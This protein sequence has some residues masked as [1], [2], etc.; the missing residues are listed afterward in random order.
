MTTPETAWPVLSLLERRVLGVLVEKAKTTPDV[1]P[2]SLNSLVN[3]CNQKSNRDPVM[4][5]QEDQI[6]ETLEVLCR[7]G[8]TMRVIGGRVDRWRQ[9]LYEAWTV[10]KL[11]L[12]ILAELLLRGPQTEA[13]L[14]R[15]SDRM[16]QF[17]DMETFKTVLKPLLDRK[18]VIYLGPENRRGTLLTH[19]FHD[20]RELEKLADHG[21]SSARNE[22][23]S[24]TEKVS[25]PPRHE[26]EASLVELKA[27][28]VSLKEQM[29]VL[30][31][32]LAALKQ[33]LGG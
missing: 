13:E 6:E 16:E 24:A 30:K 25:L 14:R 2:M 26:M 12:A 21:S 11:E 5:L 10:T 1:Y 19:G 17:P 28:I 18:L 32:Q 33:S 20:P 4:N 8:L 15:N 23:F 3:G 22:D 29:E 27:D 7:Q 9:Q 31:Q